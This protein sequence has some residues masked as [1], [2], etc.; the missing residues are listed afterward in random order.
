MARLHVV[1]EEDTN[2]A[3]GSEIGTWVLG[4]HMSR[5]SALEFVKEYGVGGRRLYIVEAP[6]VNNE[7][8]TNENTFLR[9]QRSLSRV[10]RRLGK[11]RQA[12][13]LANERLKIYREWMEKDDELVQAGGTFTAIAKGNIPAHY[14]VVMAAPEYQASWAEPGHEDD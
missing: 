10:E 3:E 11:T 9:L 4:I 8:D 14:P 1:M 7:G 2:A 13:R 6:V 5:R 12:L